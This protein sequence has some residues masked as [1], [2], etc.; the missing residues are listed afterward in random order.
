VGGDKWRLS[1]ACLSARS[2][3]SCLCL[4][5]LYDTGPGG[6]GWRLGR[7]HGGGLNR[8]TSNWRLG[9]GLQD[10]ILCVPGG[11]HSKNHTLL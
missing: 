3:D 11:A 5:R 8:E 2:E 9:E 6:T 1:L 7:G 4:P 10:A